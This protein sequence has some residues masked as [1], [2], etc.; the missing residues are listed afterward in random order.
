[1]LNLLIKISSFVVLLLAFILSAHAQPPEKMGERMQALK[2]IKLLEVLDLKEEESDKFLIKYN[3]VEKNIRDKQ[4]QLRDI[5]EDLED[6]LRDGKNDKEL[7]IL[8]S[9]L[10]K[11]HQDFQDANS[12]R[13]TDIREVLSE[14]QFA[15][16]LIFEK[17]FLEKMKE[18]LKDK[19]DRPDQEDR[20]RRR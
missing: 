9:K 19:R 3:A 4:D 1:M 2:K 16:Y 6:A 15:K 10:L 12:K 11:A 8:N 7:A 5:S 17:K 13:F 20:K 18:M 14:T